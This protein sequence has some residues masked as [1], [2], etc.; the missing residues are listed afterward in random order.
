MAE[1]QQNLIYEIIQRGVWGS[2]PIGPQFADPWNTRLILHTFLSCLIQ[3][4]KTVTKFNK[5]ANQHTFSPGIPGAPDSPL[6]PTSP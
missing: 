6:R 4:D 3:S 5:V 2:P 1:F